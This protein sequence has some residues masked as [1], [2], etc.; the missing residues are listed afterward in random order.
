M[1]SPSAGLLDDAGKAGRTRARILEVAQREASIGGIDGLTIGAL[2]SACGLSKSGLN[3]HFGSK[4]ALQVAVLDAV[5]ERF[6]R[7]V[8]MPVARVPVGRSQLVAIMERWLSWSDDPDRPGG[9]QLIAASF[10]FD[11]LDGPVRDQLACWIEAWR[12]AIRAA[13]EAANEAENASLDP[14]ATTSL[15]FGLYTSQHIERFLLDDPT[16][17]S[18]ARAAWAKLIDAQPDR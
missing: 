11:A 5:A 18:R 17:M 6:T 4:E 16:A 1:S 3:A 13:V 14:Q 8:A 12:S 2:A 7:E 10:D 9:C 15:A